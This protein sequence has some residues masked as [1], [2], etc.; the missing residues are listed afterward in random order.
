MNPLL[1]PDEKLAPKNI[2][3]WL[4]YAPPWTLEVTEQQVNTMGRSNSLIDVTNTSC[5]L[6]VGLPRSNELGE[7]FKTEGELFPASQGR[8]GCEALPNEV[9]GKRKQAWPRMGEHEFRE[10]LV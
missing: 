4:L 5:V 9:G 3:F 10:L 1:E 7:Q 6:F 2:R 8:I